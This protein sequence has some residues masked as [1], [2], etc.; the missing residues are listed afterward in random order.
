MA[1][2]PLLAISASGGQIEE[3][4]GYAR[5]LFAE[6]QQPLPPTIARE[7]GRA[8]Q[9]GDPLEQSDLLTRG[10]KLALDHAYL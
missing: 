9:S 5:D 2:W 6:S 4:L 3:A 7:L 8:L 10:V 1:L